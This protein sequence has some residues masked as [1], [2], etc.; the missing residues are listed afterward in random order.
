MTSTQSCSPIRKQRRDIAI[1]LTRNVFCSWENL[2]KRRI[3]LVQ[4]FVIETTAKNFSGALFDF[5]NV[6]QHPSCWIDGTGE[7][8]IGNVIAAAAIPRICFR[9]KRCRVLLLSPTG[10]AQAA[11]GRELQA[12]ADGQ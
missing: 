7:D 10:D 3:V 12:F 9:S 8:E 11:R 2:A 1:K 4:K 5:A 6:D